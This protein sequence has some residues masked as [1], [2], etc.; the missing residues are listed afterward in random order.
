M[1]PAFDPETTHYE[2]TASIADIAY[3]ATRGG[4][5]GGITAVTIDGETVTLSPPN[6]SRTGRIALTEGD[7]TDFSITVQAQDGVTTR[8]Y[9]VAF[10]RPAAPSVPDVTIEAS[11]SE[12]V[13]GLGNLGFTI[14]RDGGFAHDLDQTV[15]LYQHQ[16]WLTDTTFDVTISAG[17]SQV[18]FSILERD[19]SS[20]VTQSGT[21]IAT[22]AP[23]NGLDMREAR[24]SERVISQEGPA[25]QV[26]LSQ[27]SYSFGDGEG[28]VQVQLE[29]RAANGVPYVED[30]PVS[31]ISEGI[32]ATS[33]ADYFALSKPVRFRSGDF[34][35]ENGVLVGTVAENL[36][37]VEDDTFEGNE[38][39][40][41]VL[42]LYPGTPLEVDILGP[43]DT[44][45]N[46]ICDDGYLV[47]IVDNDP[48]PT[49][50]LS[51]ST[52]RIEESE[53]TAATVT[54]STV[55]GT[56][57]EDQ[58]IT[59]HFRGPSTYGEDYSVAPADADSADG[60]Q[61]TLEAREESV[62][63]TITAINDSILEP[64]E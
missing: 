64:C 1:T 20:S 28:E 60:H 17:D 33:T 43:D 46:P 42:A 24:T 52:D 27:P 49:L 45:C 31:L 30:F 54:T 62:S 12:Y 10:A 25:V 59:V 51:V 57:L 55:R 18:S 15:N 7:I 32:E 6:A 35:E 48:L 63:L 40:G 8:T 44:P 41:L 37:L 21:M 58:T 56:F 36:E 39:F 34:E 29:A 5:A 2:A 38:Q 61:V 16:P 13:A 22:V 14:T 3:E 19:F 4:M 9:H 47:T 50:N 53:T 11:H 26:S 23:G